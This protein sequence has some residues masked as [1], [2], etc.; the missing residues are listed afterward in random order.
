MTQ[1]N[2]Y[3]LLY[4]VLFH[5]HRQYDPLYKHPKKHNKFFWMDYSYV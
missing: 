2:Q 4:S 3:N 1:H 5:D